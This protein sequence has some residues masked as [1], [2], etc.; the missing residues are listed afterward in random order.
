M[1]Q[2]QVPELR[3]PPMLLSRYSHMRCLAISS[4]PVL[5]HMVFFMPEVS[6]SCRKFKLKRRTEVKRHL[7]LYELPKC[8]PRDFLT[9]SRPLQLSIL[10]NYSEELGSR[11]RRT[12]NLSSTPT[13]FSRTNTLIPED[14]RLTSRVV[15]SK[16]NE[17]LTHLDTSSLRLSSRPTAQQEYQI[18]NC[19]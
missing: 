11:F 1:S 2:L 4:I 15:Y 7:G 5:G 17:N 10:E 3:Y 13:S 12:T 8:K 19:G 16:G 9:V 18:M 6:A 14:L